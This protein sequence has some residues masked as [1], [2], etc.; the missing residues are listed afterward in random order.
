MDFR[1]CHC[2]PATSV[3]F[4]RSVLKHYLTL[5]SAALVT[6]C[7]VSVA[8]PPAYVHHPAPVVYAAPAPQAVVSVYIEPPLFQ[9]PP[10]RVMWA[11]PPMLVEL[12]PPQ[13]Y[14]DA[15]WIG[16]YWVWEGNW[17]WARGRWSDR[18]HPGYAWVHPYYEHR[19]G[20]VIFVSGFWS[21]PGVRFVAPGLDVHISLAVVAAGAI[22]GPRPIGPV[23]V[24]VPPPPGS[25][26]GLIVPAPIGTPPAV[27]LGAP[28][29]VN[30]GMRVHI[31]GH[32]TNNT[33]VNNVTNV[34]NVTN[35]TIVAPASATAN[36]Q[37]V[38]TSVPAQ[39]HLAAAQ[40]P[41]VR[42]MAPVPVSASPLPALT[43]TRAPVALP[44]A[45]MVH[46]EPA[47]VDGRTHPPEPVHPSALPPQPVVSPPAPAAQHEPPRNMEREPQ[48]RLP[49]EHAR[50]PTHEE[51]PNRPAAREN[52]PA[53]TQQQPARSEAKPGEHH[54]DE[55]VRD[56][57]HDKQRERE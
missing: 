7:A 26:M 15:V 12:V 39:A 46:P 55:R 31:D 35:V 4:G 13:P 14:P 56:K 21:A 32:N 30:E 20:A 16:G 49:A 6:G 2:A 42:A 52:R 43:P 34:S 28:P 11:P 23:G 17:V 57:E 22:P 19:D 41:M 29:V 8:P 27:V 37:A 36:G 54:P 45:R 25:R 50:P 33:V 38:N 1:S 44:P 24:F 18:P 10:L 53:P 5:A 40:A 9:P 51:M 48:T 3:I 47:A